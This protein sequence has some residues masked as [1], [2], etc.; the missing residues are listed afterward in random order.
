MLAVDYR[1]GSK[2]LIKPLQAVLGAD[3]VEETDLKFGD[4]AFTGKGA[5]G[6]PL[7][8]GIEYKKLGEMVTSIRDGRFSGHQLPGMLGKRGMYNHGWLLIEGEWRVDTDGYMTT[9]QFRLGKRPEW[10]RMPGGMRAAE[11]EKHLLTYALCGGVHVRTSRDRDDSVRVIIDLYRWWTD[12]ALDSHTSHLA[13]HTPASLDNVSDFRAAVMRWP[14]IGM[15]MSLAVENWTIER[16][17]PRSI[18]WAATRSVK[19]WSEVTTTDRQGNSKRFGELSAQKLYDFL[20]GRG[21]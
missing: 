21:Q 17:A 4:V 6:A 20:Y 11:Y 10:K 18:A 9:L 2:E 14:G 1:A 16:N 12:T 7:D 13:V 8:I 19:D 5:G 3:L 15:K